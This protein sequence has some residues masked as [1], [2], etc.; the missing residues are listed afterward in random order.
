MLFITDYYLMFESV[1]FYLVIHTVLQISYCSS[2]VVHHKL[3]LDSSIM[4]RYTFLSYQVSQKHL[5][6]FC[7]QELSNHKLSPM[8]RPT[9]TRNLLECRQDNQQ[10]KQDRGTCPQVIKHPGIKCQVA[11]RHYTHPPQSLQFLPTLWHGSLRML[12]VAKVK[13]L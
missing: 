8:P 4:P 13:R 1:L 12:H 5:C 7:H 11:S 10:P 3:W 9:L 2:S 6:Y